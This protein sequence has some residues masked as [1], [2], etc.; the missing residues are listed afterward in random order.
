M[1]ISIF[2]IALRFLPSRSFPWGNKSFYFYAIFLTEI[3]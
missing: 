2:I 1:T 3:S